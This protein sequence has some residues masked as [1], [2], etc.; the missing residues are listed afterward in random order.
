MEKLTVT[1]KDLS[2]ETNGERKVCLFAHCR[3]MKGEALVTNIVY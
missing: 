1:E 3:G 2:T